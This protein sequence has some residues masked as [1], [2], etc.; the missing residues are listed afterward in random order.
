MWVDCFIDVKLLL[1]QVARY[2]NQ[3]ALVMVTVGAFGFFGFG[4]Y[5]ICLELGVEVTYPVA[6]ATSTAFIIMSGSVMMNLFAFIHS[7]LHLIDQVK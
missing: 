1:F 2:P 5:P 7:P 4:L 3:H 6:E